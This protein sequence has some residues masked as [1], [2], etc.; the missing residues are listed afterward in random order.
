MTILQENLVLSHL[1]L[2]R[3][4]ASI[5]KKTCSF[6]AYDELESAAFLGLT[7][8]AI[9]YDSK[10]SDNFAAFAGIRIVGAIQDYLREL[11]WGSRNNPLKREEI[12]S[13]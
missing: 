3:K 1:N 13:F 6:I 12:C 10:I 2:A 9:K 7:E 11:S 5:K 4:F 8:A